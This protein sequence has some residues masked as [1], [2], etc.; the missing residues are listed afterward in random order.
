MHDLK[1]D[2]HLATGRDAVA[3]AFMTGSSSLFKAFDGVRTEVS[4]RL[5]ERE[6]ALT[7]PPTT[8]TEK[9]RRLSQSTIASTSESTTSGASLPVS[10]ISRLSPSPRATS[11]P[12][13]I[14]PPQIA[15][16]KAALGNIGSGIGSFFGSRVASFR[17]GP[18]PAPSTGAA[19]AVAPPPPV[20]GLRPM[21][22]S[23]TLGVPRTGVDRA[24]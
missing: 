6:T 16:V 23:G 12:V 22:L 17:G 19:V 21:S 20:K 13:S 14:Q 15:D 18:P 7:P 2:Q 8:L 11:T 3:S 1:I 10:H 5:K 4:T 9:D 24:S